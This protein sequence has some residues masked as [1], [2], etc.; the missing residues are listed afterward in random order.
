MCYNY[1]IFKNEKEGDMAGDRKTTTTED[2]SKNAELNDLNQKLKNAKS[3]A[4]TLRKELRDY[5][6]RPQDYRAALAEWEAADKEVKELAK[7]VDRVSAGISK[8]VFYASNPSA[9]VPVK[10]PLL[11]RMNGP[12]NNTWGKEATSGRKVEGM[13]PPSTTDEEGNKMRRT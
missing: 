1:I 7:E 8:A 6:S 12:Y 9:D 13:T 11:Q 10:Q 4:D 2:T 5:Y 3:Y